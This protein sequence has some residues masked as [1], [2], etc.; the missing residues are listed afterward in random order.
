MRRL[1]TACVALAYTQVAVGDE[2]V[3]ILEHNE[4]VAPWSEEFKFA[5]PPFSVEH[6][7]RLSLHARIAADRLKGSN[8]WLKVAANGTYLGEPALLNKPNEFTLV[9]GLDLLWVKHATFRVLY[10]PDFQAAI[11]DGENPYACPD[12]DP[13]R[14]VLDITPYVQPGENILR[15]EHLQV[16]AKPSTMIIRNVQ[17]EVGKPITRED[18][19]LEPAPTGPLPTFVPRRPQE[20]EMEVGLAG[21]GAISLRVGGREVVVTTRTS[22]PGG[23]WLETDADEARSS[24]DGSAQASWASG[25]FQIEREVMVR[26]DHVHVEDTVTNVGDELAGMMIEHHARLDE[27]PVEV[28]IA[29]QKAYTT[30]MRTHNPANPSM[31]AQW[32]DMG[33]GLVAEDDILRVHN[34]CLLTEESLGIGDNR[35]GLEAGNSVTLEW[36]IYPVPGGDYWDFANAVRRNWGSNF[37]IPGPFVFGHGLHSDRSAEAFGKWARDRSLKIICGGIA[38]YPDRRYAHGTAMTFARDW[39]SREKNWIQKMQEAAPEVWPVC[40]FHSFCS[41][42]PDGERKYTDA[43]MINGKGEH[44][45]YPYRYRLPLYVPTNDNSY[46][47]ALWGFVDTILEDIGAAGVYWDEMSHSVLWYV[48][49][50]PWDG[51]SVRFDP[52]THEV[53]GKIT[54]VALATQE[55]RLEIVQ[56][57]RDKGKFLMGNTQP[58]TQT[59][60]NEKVV[61]F[62]ETGTYSAMSNTHLECPLGLG[63]HHL[64][65]TPGEVVKIIR[66]LLQHGGTWYGWH[67]LYEPPEW[68]FSSVMFPITPVEIREGMVLGEERI[69]TARSGIFGFADGAPAEVYV[70]GGDGMRVEDPDV[71]EIVEDGRHLY[72]IRMPGDQFAVVVKKGNGR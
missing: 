65:K 49:G 4:S 47:K 67:Y 32:Q 31:F 23:Q 57:V 50:A 37:T 5:V 52:N 59:M 54:S 42:E 40:Y 41:T 71:K 28:R 48:F 6:Q 70:V 34:R 12:A 55:L 72:E 44:V 56:H 36:S 35:L 8:H 10:S 63:N 29:G 2:P 60:H 46:G 33:L 39:V 64:D 19:E 24:V 9:Q 25:S 21:G 22:L 53:L 1:L 20:V 51:C 62:V 68:N 15:L 11:I 45:G 26:S 58:A 17:V 43:R 61:R 69:H 18:E 13:Y 14:F 16:L 7:V 30:Q 66:N 3:M 38:Q 27:P